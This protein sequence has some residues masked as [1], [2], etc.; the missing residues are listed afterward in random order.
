VKCEVHSKKIIKFG[1]IIFIILIIIII[2]QLLSNNDLKVGFIQDNFLNNE[3]YEN[4]E[5]R[6]VKSRLFGFEKWVTIRYETIGNYSN[7]LT[8]TTINTFFLLDENEMYI[9]M[10]EII[11]NFFEDGIII[12][13]SSKISGERLL[14]NGHRSLYSIFDGF[15]K[16]KKYIE[17]IKVIIEV[18][19]CGIEGNSIICYGYS[20]IT[21]NKHNNSNI[22]TIY[23]NK[24]VGDLSINFENNNF[25]NEDT[26]IYNVICH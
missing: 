11:D 4:L 16:S 6:E 3:W 23:W 15:D 22:N 5:Y 8:I 20:Q 12:N 25:I 10:E 21:D 18:W 7:F 9:K 17:K 14:K 1:I 26:L 24:I 19:N 2:S 13:R